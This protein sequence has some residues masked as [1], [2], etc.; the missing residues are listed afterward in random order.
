MQPEASPIFPEDPE[1]GGNQVPESQSGKDY[2]DLDLQWLSKKGEDRGSDSNSMT[3]EEMDA[4]ESRMREQW[5]DLPPHEQREK[6]AEYLSS[7]RNREERP[8]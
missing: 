7:R 1:L 5:K 3:R 8:N 6:T 2:S 4:V